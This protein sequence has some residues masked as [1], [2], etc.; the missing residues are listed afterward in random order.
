MEVIDNTEKRRFETEVDGHIAMVEYIL[1]EEDIYLTHTEVPKA[2]GGR[3][4][5]HDLVDTIFNIV[6]ERGM[7]IVPLCPYVAVYLKRHPERAS[8]LKDGFGVK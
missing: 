8:Q 3:G 1:R 5:A 6:A 4:I 2:I 7:K